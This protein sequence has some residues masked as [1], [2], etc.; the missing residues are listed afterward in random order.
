MSKKTPEGDGGFDG[1]AESALFQARLH[2]HFLSLSKARKASGLPVFALEHGL[3][4][5]QF[6]LLQTSV[7]WLAERRLTFRPTPPTPLP[8]VVYAA[9]IG[10]RY[11]GGEI[12]PIELNARLTS[13]IPNFGFCDPREP[14]TKS[15]RPDSSWRRNTR[16]SS[17]AIE[18][19]SQP[20]RS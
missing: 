12:W 6:K 9:E 2:E 19:L 11:D 8:L 20:G 10:Y 15:W 14:L 18:R 13:L 4:D 17:A 7:R 16:P 1:K 5:G 3:S